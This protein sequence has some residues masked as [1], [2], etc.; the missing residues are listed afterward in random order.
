MKKFI[1]NR[2][3][4]FTLIAV[5][6]FYVL[7]VFVKNPGMNTYDRAMFHDIIYGT[8]WKPY[9]YRVIIP[10]IT[11]TATSLIPERFQNTLSE[12]V[13]QNKNIKAV[14]EKFHWDSK[15]ITEYLIA[16]FLMYLS[17]IGFVYAFRKLFNAIYFVPHWFVNLV[18]IFVLLGLPAMFEYYSYVYD[19]PTLFL[20]TLGLYLILKK[21]WKLFLLLYLVPCFNK[22]TTILLTLVF[23]IHYYGSKEIDKRHYRNLILI[24]LVIFTIIKLLLFSIFINNPGGF[25]EF[26]LFD[27]TYLLWNGYNLA[28]YVIWLIIALLVFSKWNEKPNF[29]KDAL[30]IAV[31]LII[32]TFFLGLWDEWRDYYEVY[33]VIILLISYTVARFVGVDIKVINGVKQKI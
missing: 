25:V 31:P 8:A 12:T 24:Q 3:I 26:H 23:A 7:I 6:S 16:C 18:T 28:T 21:N 20:F 32:L 27:R 15:D 14:L 17:L 30:W 13:E 29:L 1:E 9:V 33:P 5:V 10:V 11:R 4:Y 22:E 19:F 2:F